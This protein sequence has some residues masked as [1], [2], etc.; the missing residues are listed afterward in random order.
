MINS[1][2][3]KASVDMKPTLSYQDDVIH[4]PDQRQWGPG[5]LLYRWV[6]L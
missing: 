4:L 3:M 5:R 6:G 1:F 2:I